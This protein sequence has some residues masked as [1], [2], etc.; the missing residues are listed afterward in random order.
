M[1]WMLPSPHGGSRPDDSRYTANVVTKI[2]RA[3]LASIARTIPS[4]V[5]RASHGHRTALQWH[6]ASTRG[7]RCRVVTQAI[8]DERAET[9]GVPAA[10]APSPDDIARWIYAYLEHAPLSLALREI[11]RLI[12]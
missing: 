9:P 10:S 5:A 1:Y 11:N 4:L 7:V 3:S 12:A 8:P 6:C 2:A